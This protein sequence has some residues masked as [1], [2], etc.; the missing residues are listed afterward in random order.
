MID[1]SGFTTDSNISW[2]LVNSQAQIPLYGYFQSNNAGGFNDVIF[3]DNLDA[4]S[5]KLYFGSDVNND[6]KFDVGAPTTYVEIDIPCPIVQQQVPT[7]QLPSIQQQPTQHSGI[8]WGAICRALQGHI[9]E[10]CETLTTSD[11]YI[12]TQEGKR[13]VACFLGG[14]LL[15]AADKTGV[16]F[17]VAKQLASEV[18]CG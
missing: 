7:Q 1:G 13:V 6:D 14:A 12:L 5:Y 4:D 2:K 18:T 15:L 9:S 8:N 16:A 17:E 11:G 10:P 3:T